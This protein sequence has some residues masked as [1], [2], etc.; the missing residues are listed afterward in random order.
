MKKLDGFRVKQG[1]S[2]LD[3]AMA[4]MDDIE[5]FIREQ[6]ADL[7]RKLGDNSVVLMRGHGFAAAPIRNGDRKKREATEDE[8]CDEV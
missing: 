2:K 8:R 6:G 5:R 1:A 4:L 7:A 3:L